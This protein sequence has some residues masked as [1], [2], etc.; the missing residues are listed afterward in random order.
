[1]SKNGIIALDADGVLLDYNLAYA[2]AW[3]KAFGSYPR[4][5]DITGYSPLD[6]WDVDHLSG[7][8]LSKLR[9]SFNEVF[10]RTVP[11]IEGALEACRVL[12]G[13]GYKLICVSALSTDFRSARL[14]NLKSHGFPIEVLHVVAHGDGKRSPKADVLNDIRPVAFVDDYLPYFSGVDERIHRALI[15]R[16]AKGSP[17]QGESLRYSSSQHE[18]LI[19]F[20][21][22]WV[23]REPA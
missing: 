12:A 8:K 1:M 4:E 6:R 9:S 13:A 3:E 20:A 14:E 15:M 5:K 16:G 18:S 10:W 19:K 21:N 2:S 23:T 17:N 7:E 11:A 22:W